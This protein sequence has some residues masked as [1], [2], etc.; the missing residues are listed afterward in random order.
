MLNEGS[1][2]KNLMRI[3][4]Y[5]LFIYFFW[6]SIFCLFYLDQNQTHSILKENQNIDREMLTC[7]F[8]TQVNESN[9]DFFG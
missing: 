2:V 5:F 6:S 1:R 4:I 7:T 3:E 9:V 8:K